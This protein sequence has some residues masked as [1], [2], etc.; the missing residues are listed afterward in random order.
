MNARPHPDAVR[1]A[2]VAGPVLDVRRFSAGLT[3]EGPRIL[4]DVS[5]EVAQIGRAHV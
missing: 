5:F 1:P 4:D 2:A 3:A